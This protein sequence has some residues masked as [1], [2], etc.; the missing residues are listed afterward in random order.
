MPEGQVMRVKDHASR[1]SRRAIAV[2]PEDRMPE[3]GEMHPNLMGPARLER[4]NE[5]RHACFFLRETCKN[6]GA[7]FLALDQVYPAIARFGG[8]ADGSIDEVGPRLPASVHQG[9]IGPANVAPCHGL[10]EDGGRPRMARGKQ[11]A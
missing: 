9:S 10:A 3:M 5:P 11:Q 4:Q 8:P 2:V 6:P 1:H 7:G